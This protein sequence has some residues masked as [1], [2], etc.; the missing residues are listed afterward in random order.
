MA[1]WPSIRERILENLKAKFLT[2]TVANGYNL[3]VRTVERD[4]RNP[5]EVNKH[6]AIF[7]TG[8]EELPLHLS[9]QKLRNEFKPTVV[10]YA[11]AVGAEAAA[12]QAEKLIQ[13]IK[14][15]FFSDIRRGG[16][17][18]TSLLTAIRIDRGVLPPLAAVELDL[19]IFYRNPRGEP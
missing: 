3:D 19:Q 11:H 5:S 10:G 4:L 18:E 17:A 14:T 8:G 13:D 9:F 7:L 15:A 12:T 2:I 1:T 6:P 16:L